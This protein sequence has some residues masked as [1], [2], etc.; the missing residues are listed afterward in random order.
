MCIRTI[1]TKAQHIITCIN[2]LSV[3]LYILV[4]NKIHKLLKMVLKRLQDI[5][6][7]EGEQ[8]WVHHLQLVLGY[9]GGLLKVD[10]WYTVIGR[11]TSFQSENEKLE[12]KVVMV[13]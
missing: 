10:E 12:K 7:L 5:N 1:K 9:I 8:S 3:N 6:G 13:D 2:E 11:F 4:S